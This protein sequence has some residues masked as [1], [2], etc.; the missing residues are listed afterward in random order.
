MAL[1]WRGA[2][3]GLR[4]GSRR[5]HRGARARG[6]RR[7]AGTAASARATLP[8]LPRRRDRR[9]PAL[10]RR[11]HRVR[12]ARRRVGLDGAT[13]A[14]RSTP[15]ACPSSCTTNAAGNF[16]ATPSQYN[17]TFPLH[18]LVQGPAGHTAIMQ[19]LDRGQRHGRAQRRAARAATSIPAGPARP[20]TCASRS[21]TEGRRHETPAS[22]RV[23]VARRRSPACSV[24]P[25]DGAVHPAGPARRTSFPAVAQLLD[26]RCGSLDCHG[27]VARNLRL[28]GSA[29]L[30]LVAGRPSTRFPSAT[31]RTKWIRTTSP[32][33]I[34]SRRR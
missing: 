11:R 9:S 29:G 18:V 13:V 8:A 22:A 4:S 26:V 30:R 6:A 19:T 34:S 23:P 2:A 24:P 16:Y 10:H 28:Y 12:D 31:P 3:R 32:W 14:S 1:S 25:S 17:P 21:T 5:R 15:T 20:A 27:T 33:S 7:S